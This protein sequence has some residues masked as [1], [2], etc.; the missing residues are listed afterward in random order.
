[1]G[2]S[3]KAVAILEQNL[4]MGSMDQPSITKQHQGSCG[5]ILF[6]SL[7]ISDD[8]IVDAMYEYIGAFNEGFYQSDEGAFRSQS[9]QDC[10]DASTQNHVCL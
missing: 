10:Q 3:K 7:R 8:R 1:M 4:N 2:F 9:G 6:L 5:D